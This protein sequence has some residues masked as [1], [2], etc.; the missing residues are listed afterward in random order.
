[1]K[2]YK[3]QKGK[4]VTGV[5]MTL[6]GIILLAS[7]SGFR[8]ADGESVAILVFTMLIFIGGILLIIFSKKPEFYCSDCGNFRGTTPTG[9]CQRCGCNV[10]TKEYTGSGTTQRIQNKY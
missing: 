8:I 1:M 7:L 2:T 4:I 10:V 5:L 6:F 9:A 3:R